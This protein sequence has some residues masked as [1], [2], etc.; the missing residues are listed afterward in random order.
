MRIVILCGSL[1]AGCDG[2]GD[3]TRALERQLAAM[4]H[5]VTC[6]ALNDSFVDSSNCASS[7]FIDIGRGPSQFFRLSQFSS[8]LQ[9]LN[10]VHR[11]L[12]SYQPEW[13]SLQ[14]V[15]YSFS[16]SGIPLLF[17]FFAY[18]LCGRWRTHIMFHELW[19]DGQTSVTAFIMRCF[20]DLLIRAIAFVLDPTVIHTSIPHYVKLLAGIGIGSSILPLHGNIPVQRNIVAESIRSRVW[21][22]VFFGS[23]DCKWSFEPLY[24][25]IEQAR[26]EG[27]IQE[28]I[29]LRIGKFKRDQIALWSH[30]SNPGICSTY[31]CFSFVDLGML[32]EEAVSACLLQSSF[33]ISMAPFQWI[34]KSGSVAAMLDHGLPV[35]VPSY[36]TTIPMPL[37]HELPFSDRLIAIDDQLPQRLLKARKHIVA[38]SVDRTAMQLLDAFHRVA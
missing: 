34:G 13:V 29:F 22:F 32:G 28:C 19:I 30:I 25:L 3:Y 27:N 10:C 16:Q 31:S 4:G 7:T 1:E 14:Y 8:W 12:E 35:V 33:G 36:P 18:R 5:N 24:H 21:K 17:T 37:S 6:I 26:I 38:E 20:Q 23:L 2:V 11:Y 9:K 15:P